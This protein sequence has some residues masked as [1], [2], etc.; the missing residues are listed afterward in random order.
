MQSSF[1]MLPPIATVIIS[2][3]KQSIIGA[4]YSLPSL[5]GNER[6][7]GQPFLVRCVCAKVPFQKIFRSLSHSIGFGKAIRASLNLMQAAIS[8]TLPDF[9]DDLR[10]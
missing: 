8:K 3:A 7:I 6:Y 5:H 1:F 2:P 9:R 10:V 4:I